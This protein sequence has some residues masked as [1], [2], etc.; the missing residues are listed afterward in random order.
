M[1]RLESAPPGGGTLVLIDGT[2]ALCGRFARFVIRRD[3]GGRIRF[4]ALA[5]AAAGSELARR[6]L[7]APPAGTVVLIEGGRAF[8]RSE[9]AL[10]ILAML[11]FPWSLARTLRAIPAALRDPAYSLVA[12]LRH[13]V[14]GSTH[15]CALLTADE[16][17]RFLPDAGP[18]EPG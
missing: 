17:R 18:S 1:S 2:C 5:S 3:P 7:P 8:F 9:A 14:F 6:G 11:P 13:R 16:H 10:R 15:D 4:A 12:R